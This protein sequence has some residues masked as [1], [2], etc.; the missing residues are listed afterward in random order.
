VG[1]RERTRARKRPES[2]SLTHPPSNT[3]GYRLKLNRTGEQLKALDTAFNRWLKRDAYTLTE[4]HD[5]DTGDDILCLE[6]GSPPNPEWGV[7][8][9]ECVHNL[10][11]ALDQLIYALAWGNT[12][13]PLTE[14]VAKNSEFPIYGPR[15]PKAAELRRRI[16]AL[17]PNAQTIIKG[18][19]PCQ[20]RDRFADDEL[21]ILDQLWNLDKHRRITVT[22]LAVSGAAIGRPGER[23]YVESFQWLGARPPMQGKTELARYRISGKVD[24]KRIPF[25]DVAFGQGSPAYGAAVVP[26]LTRLRSYV[27]EKVVAP[28]ASFP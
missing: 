24:V 20:R 26:T 2:E 25:I 17:D 9:G 11:S 8:I 19:Q 28:L 15:W 14:R 10:R 6:P 4:E 23:F 27:E 16:G 18:L 3:P 7:L 21:W 1:K 12:N 22:L 5:L 13:G